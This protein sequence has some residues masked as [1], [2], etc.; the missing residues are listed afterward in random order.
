RYELLTVEA[1]AQEYLVTEGFCCLIQELLTVS[2]PH[3]LGRG[4]RA[5]G[6]WPYVDFVL[7]DVLLPARER[8]HARP[9]ERWRLVAR[10]LQVRV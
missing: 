2:M 10:A 6:L 5:P 9:G 3:G 4:R 1:Q 7:A 8:R